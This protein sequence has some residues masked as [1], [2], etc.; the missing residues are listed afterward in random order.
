VTRRLDRG[1]GALA[2]LLIL[3]ACG[4]PPAAPAPAITPQ[5]ALDIRY[6]VAIPE[7]SSHYLQVELGIA[8]LSVDSIDLQMPVWSPGR[9]ARMDF[10]RNV[11]RFEATASGGRAIPVVRRSGSL[12]RL[13]TR[14]DSVIAIRYRVFANNLSGTFTVA[15]A[16]HV[17]WNGGSI[18]M[19]VVGHK[20]DPVRLAVVPPEGWQ[21][22][23]GA[24][25]D[26]EQRDFAFPNY[27][28]L[29]D[30]PT[31]IAPRIA[32]D[33]F[34][35]DGRVY[36]LMI[37][38]AGGDAGQ[39]TRFDRDV[40]KLVRYENTIVGPP[41]I[42]RY[43]FLFHIGFPGGDGME[44]LAS[45]QIINHLAW[46]DTAVILPGIGT[47]AH[48]YVHVW[49]VK[50]IRPAALGP[51]DYTTEQ[52]E[53]SLWVAEGWTQYYG[54]IALVRTG[55]EDRAA[56]YRALESL[57]AYNSTLPA[58]RW[59]SA[60]DASFLAPFWDG[61]ASPMR[62]DI[63]ES[64]ISYYPKGAALAL[65]LD[66]EIRARSNGARSLDNALRNLKKRSWDAPSASYYLQ[67]HGYTEQDVEAA[68]SEAAGVDLHPWFDK[69]VGGTEE[70]P[71]ADALA[72]V[73]LRLTVHGTGADR[74]FSVEEAADATPA[75]KRLRD[76]WLAGT[77]SAGDNAR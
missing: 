53:P 48:E 51:F 52:Y 11:Q 69:Y 43:T 39:R 45:T 61:A 30:T 13:T 35:V 36:R 28:I 54:E 14:G 4:S 38:L 16:D 12:W 72:L 74:T 60:R 31:E 25:T 34:T 32:V 66:L 17:N 37:H 8:G 76:S 41:P 62:T 70:L 59:V 21:V 10:A 68:V 63:D 20:S 50:R 24:S 47:A 49:N 40:E 42:E 56:Y 7:P 1:G 22:L 9:Y 15:D 71:F 65:L 77:T 6:R 46:S 5:R 3:A 23:N 44:H 2:L 75:Q 18:F 29:I 67:G 33:S 58:R 73:G 27:D 57:I 19:Y 64:F 55:I 26:L